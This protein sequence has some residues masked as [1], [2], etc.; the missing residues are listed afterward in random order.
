MGKKIHSLLP[1]ALRNAESSV[2]PWTVDLLAE[3]LTFLA[4]RAEARAASRREIGLSADGS[5][6]QLRNLLCGRVAAYQVTALHA[7]R[8][9]GLMHSMLQLSCFV[10][11]EI[12]VPDADLLELTDPTLSDHA[13]KQACWM[14]ISSLSPSK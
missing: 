12:G 6:Q 4:D 3:Q 8:T 5:P 11:S 10:L 1:A 2:S 7:Y 13:T 9:M 14:T